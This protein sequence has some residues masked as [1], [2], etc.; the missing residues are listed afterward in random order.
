MAGTIFGLPLSQQMNIDGTPMVGALLYLYLANTTTPVQSFSDPSLAVT[1]LQ[2]WPLVTDGSGRLPAFWLGDGSYR[3]RLLDSMGVVQFDWMNVLAIGPSTGG[4]GGGGPPPP[5]DPNSLLVTGDVIWRPGADLRAGFVRLN[6]NTIGPTGSPASEGNGTIYQNLF[7]YIWQNFTAPSSGGGNP[8]GLICPIVGASAIGPSAISDW[9]NGRTI[10]LLDMRGRAPFGRDQMGAGVASGNF[11]GVPIISGATADQG[12]APVGKNLHTLLITELA[13]HQHSAFIDD[14]KHHHSFP[15]RGGGVQ[16]TTGGPAAFPLA[17]P[18][19]IT[20]DEL[21]GIRVKSA[22]GPSG[23]PPADE[24]TALTGGGGSHNNV[25]F[26]IV[27]T[28]YWRL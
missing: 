7:I 11:T 15:V 12:G 16:G 4:G 10:T 22:A 23:T 5:V 13:A 27:G 28:W 1:A 3:A 6:G 25:P 26:G 20:S 21:T 2:P 18:G 17:P 24:Q 8:A 19:D 14:P 9:N